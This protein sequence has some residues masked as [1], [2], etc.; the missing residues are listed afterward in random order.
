[1]PIYRANTSK[2]LGSR[3]IGDFW[4]FTPEVP[5]GWDVPFDVGLPLNVAAPPGGGIAPVVMY[6][7]K[8]REDRMRY[9]KQSTAVDLAIGPFVDATDAV[10]AETALT[11]TQPDIRLKKNGGAWGQKN[12]AQTLSHEENG[13]YEVSLD[14]TDT[15]TLGVLALA[16]HEAGALPVWH[17]FMV[18][19]ANVYDS[20]VGGSDT[21][22]VQVTGIGASVITA[23]AIAADAITDAKVASDVTIASVTGAVGSVTGAVGSV[24]G[25][26]GSVTGNVGGNVV[27]SVGS[28]T[29]GVTLADDA[30]TSAKVAASAVTELQAGL[31]TQ[32][33]VDTIDG[34]VDAILVDT[35][36]IGAAGAG[37]TALASQASV[38]T[39]DDFLDT[40]IAAIL[41]DTNELQTDI[42]NGGRIDLLIDAIKAKT[43]LIPASPAATGDIPSAASIADAVWDEDATAHQTQGTFG[44]AIGD[45]GAD[46]DTIWGLANTNLNATVSSRASQ[47]SLDTLDDFV[48]TEV[49]AIK[50]K[51][52]NLPASP[53][54]TG[55]IPTAA[56]VADAVWDEAIAGHLSA[57]STGLAL[58]S[59]GAAGDPWSTAVPGAYGA[60]TA[61][62]ILGDNLN[63]TVSSRASQTS[64]D[65]VDDF[66]DTEIAAIK[67]KTDNLPS[68]PA[69]Q[70]A[71]EAAITAATSGLATAAALDTV[72]N[73]IDTEVTAI[74]AVTDKLDTALELDG[75][76]YRY[77]TNALEQAP[78][79][80]G[81]ATAGEIADAVLDEALAGHA[82]AG[83]LG[84]AI[85]DVLA[86]TAEIGAAGAGLTAVPWNASWDA[87]VQSEATD[88][89]NAYDAPT[90]AEMDAKIDA[91]PGVLSGVTVRAYPRT[92]N[93]ENFEV[94]QGDDY[95]VTAAMT[96]VLT[97]APDLTAETVN[98]ETLHYSK[99]CEVSG[100]VLAGWTVVLK[101]TAGQSAA[102]RPG[103]HN[104][105]LVAAVAGT[106][107]VIGV[108]T[109]TA[110][111]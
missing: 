85:S 52:D 94:I 75:A 11:I 48:D 89:L 41:A 96:W 28:V 21:L 68:D 32:A 71:V 18:L 57:G 100:S 92:I 105:D 66:L 51:T 80:G 16:V 60:G 27:G 6:Y 56:A 12:A 3:Q 34:I 58:N 40:E 33:S 9:L 50:A 37:L 44:Q 87:E 38:N 106:T 78:S 107:L 22:D 15:G 2:S 67:A 36:E 93:T 101:L 98:F 20:L 79:G 13:W 59:A 61:G 73:F 63:A 23:A 30:I 14:A 42:T 82:T 77:T 65:T 74:K 54:A 8:R 110:E 19:P 83:T 111:N 5:D 91:L 1:M 17:E 109:V 47:T 43:D 49:A 25:A 70:S 81:G 35:A 24:T 99:A 29:A 39:I 88:A 10:T 55:D 4:R 103:S 86:D 64:V 95:S 84:K 69:D 62:K 53:A 46:T 102:L 97:D 76:V 104:Y 31:A 108:M 72:D 26:V 7:R 45:P 90:K